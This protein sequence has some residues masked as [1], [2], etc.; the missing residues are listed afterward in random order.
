MRLI[1]AE[2]RNNFKCAICGKQPVKYFIRTFIEDIDDMN[3]R[4]YAFC[5]LCALKY[6]VNEH[7]HN[8][9]LEDEER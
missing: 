4:E 1:P 8:T 9:C 2:K 7:E 5:N 3:D 6:S